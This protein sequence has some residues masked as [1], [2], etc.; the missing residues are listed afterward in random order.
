MV[1]CTDCGFEGCELAWTGEGDYLCC[2][3]FLKIFPTFDH[4]NCSPCDKRAEEKAR[5]LKQQVS[6]ENFL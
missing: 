3:C 2:E 5:I 4:G 6:L 1:K